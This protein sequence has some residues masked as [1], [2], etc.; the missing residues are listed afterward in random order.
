MSGKCSVPMLPRL[1]G[2]KKL[3]YIKPL[4]KLHKTIDVRDDHLQEIGN[5][6]TEHFDL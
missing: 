1:A 6:A 4:E 5:L 3:K 2:E